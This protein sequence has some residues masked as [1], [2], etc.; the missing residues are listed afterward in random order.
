MNEQAINSVA[1]SVLRSMMR[2]SFNDD[3][4]S[5][6]QVGAIANAITAA[7]KEYDKQQKKNLIS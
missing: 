5:P 6:K 2:V 7:I 4:F 3:S 1:S